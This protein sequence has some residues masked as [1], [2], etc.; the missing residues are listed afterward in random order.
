MLRAGVGAMPVLTIDG[1]T[2]TVIGRKHALVESN[3]NP[4]T[5]HTVGIDDGEWS[6]TCIG[7]TTRKRCRHVTALKR[8][9]NGEADVTIEED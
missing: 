6:C 5:H 7:F 8:W 9:L 1:E 4:G 2:V 3:S